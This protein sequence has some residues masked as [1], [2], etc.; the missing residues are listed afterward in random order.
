MYGHPNYTVMSGLIKNVYYINNN[1]NFVFL[2]I[3][4]KII[5]THLYFI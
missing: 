4:I 1:H 5:L 2:N 3:I